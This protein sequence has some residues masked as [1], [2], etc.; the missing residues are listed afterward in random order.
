MLPLCQAKS[1]TMP[2]TICPTQGTSV[3]HSQIISRHYLTLSPLNF[4]L[5]VQWI[6]A[7]FFHQTFVDKCGYRHITVDNVPFIYCTE[8]NTFLPGSDYIIL[9]WIPSCLMHIFIPDALKMFLQVNAYWSFTLLGCGLL[10]S[11]FCDVRNFHVAPE[12][13]HQYFPHLYILQVQANC[14]CSCMLY[15][16]SYTASS[17]TC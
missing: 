6:I 10:T 3:F 4:M 16:D 12:Y 13:L 11:L 9:L 2:K 7:S 1:A 17:H 8:L 5:Y 15:R 14:F